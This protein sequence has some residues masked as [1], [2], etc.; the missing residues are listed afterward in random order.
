MKLAT[1]SIGV[2]MLGVGTM[3][4]QGA[5][6]IDLG[7]AVKPIEDFGTG[8]AKAGGAVIKAVTNGAELPAW[9]L[10]FALV[11]L[12]VRVFFTSQATDKVVQGRNEA[13]QQAHAIAMA[14]LLH[15]QEMEKLRAEAELRRGTDGDR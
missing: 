6:L 11:V 12:L 1:L 4:Q 10:A 15:E 2:G 13:R 9:L 14:K 5:T 3:M 8:A 7:E